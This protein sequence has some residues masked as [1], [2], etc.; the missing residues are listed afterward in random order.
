MHI[1]R[2]HDMYGIAPLLVIAPCHSEEGNYCKKYQL[3]S[4]HSFFILLYNI[5]LLNQSI[6]PQIFIQH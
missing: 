3:E 6:C 5:Q 4:S 2:M 1:S